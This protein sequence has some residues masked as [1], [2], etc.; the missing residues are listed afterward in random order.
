[1]GRE[2]LVVRL[3]KAIATQVA[4]DDPQQHREQRRCEPVRDV[5]S[6]AKE[7]V[8]WLPEKVLGKKVIAATHADP[9]LTRMDGRITRDV[10]SG[11]AGAD[12]QHLLSRELRARAVVDRG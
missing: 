6:A 5:W 11:I 3:R 4:D 12:H 2:R 1:M 10:A 7:L 8:G 9:R